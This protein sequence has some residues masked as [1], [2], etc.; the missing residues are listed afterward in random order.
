LNGSRIWP[1]AL[2][3]GVLTTAWFFV[4]DRGHLEGKEVEFYGTVAVLVAAHLVFGFAIGRW[5]PLMLPAAAVILAIPWGFPETRFE[6]TFPLFF[7]QIS[8]AIPETVLLAFGVTTRKLSNWL[9]A[10]AS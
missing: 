2:A 5:W 9:S 10:R 4:V 1:A 6:E 3:Y 8:Y 7:V